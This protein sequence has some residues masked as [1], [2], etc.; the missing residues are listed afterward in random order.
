M[1]GVCCWRRAVSGDMTHDT[2]IPPVP[3]YVWYNECLFTS[4]SGL[5]VLFGAP[6]LRCPVVDL[7]VVGEHT[8]EPELH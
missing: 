8:T 4:W 5:L 6:F 3:D 7:A 1:A 2:A